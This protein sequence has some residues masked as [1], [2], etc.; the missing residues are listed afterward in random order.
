VAFDLPLAVAVV[1]RLEVAIACQLDKAAQTWVKVKS[2]G[3]VAGDHDS[4]QQLELG[5]NRVGMGALRAVMG[6]LGKDHGH[7]GLYVDSSDRDTYHVRNHGPFANV[8]EANGVAACEDRKHR[9]ENDDDAGFCQ[10]D[11]V[12][13]IMSEQDL[14]A[15]SALLVRH[16]S[17]LCSHLFET[18]K[19]S[20][21]VADSLSFH[22]LFRS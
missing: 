14:Q 12:H 4:G 16:T 1:F 22:H 18:R 19:L 7:A 10:L 5:L 21:M 2:T 8:H 3:N 15:A 13:H 20:Q 17:L 6:V 11:V 9:V